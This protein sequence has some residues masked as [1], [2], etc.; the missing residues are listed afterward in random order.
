[1]FKPNAKRRESKEI[2]REKTINFLNG[3]LLKQGEDVDQS[4]FYYKQGA[5]LRPKDNKLIKKTEKNE[6]GTVAANL[7]KIED[8][9]NEIENNGKNSDY[10]VEM[11]TH[12]LLKQGIKE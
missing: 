10:F 9:L 6:I 11:I 1:M 7:F 3:M 4:N 8:I 12:E 2:L 5:L